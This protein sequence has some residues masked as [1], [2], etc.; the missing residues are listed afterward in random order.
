[1]IMLN[2][3]AYNDHAY[4]DHAYNDHANDHFIMIMLNNHV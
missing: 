2:D 4:N 1:M 3:H